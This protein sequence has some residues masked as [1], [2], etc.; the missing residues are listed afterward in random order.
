MKRSTP[1]DQR[2]E[3]R[4]ADESRVTIRPVEPG[5]KPLLAAALAELSEES[6]YRRFFTPLRELG[7]RQ[8][9]DLTEVD[10]HDDEALVAIDI[11]SGSCV[12]VARFVRSG[13]EVAEPAVVVVDRWQR[14]G[15][16]T[17]LAFLAP[18][19]AFIHGRSHDDE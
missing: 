13:D 1:I 15:L 12:G 16:G 8:L 2:P 14:R 10:H 17:A 5:D 11:R 4:L 7:A 9:A 18:A 3:V 6:R 19:R